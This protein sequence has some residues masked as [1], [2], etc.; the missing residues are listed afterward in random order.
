MTKVRLYLITPLLQLS[1]VEAFAPR[2][3]AALS[4]GDVASTLVR[5]A[6]GAEGDARRIVARLL[7]ATMPLDVALLVENDARLAARVAAD[8]VHVAADAV[9]EA[10]ASLRSER[11]V[12]AGGLRLRDDAMAAG[13]AGAD[14]V[15]FG[16]PDRDGTLVAFEETLERI[17]WWAEIFQMPCVGY[18]ASLDEAEAL[19]A[20]GADFVALGELVWDAPLPE[21]IVAAASER[22]AKAKAP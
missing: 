16:E 9:A 6:P 13:E 2:F 10:V 14:Y 7:E 15:M 12:G 20:A 18:A 4:A 19:T 22:I 1:E 5:L 21:A 17:G 11:I 8:G 3:A